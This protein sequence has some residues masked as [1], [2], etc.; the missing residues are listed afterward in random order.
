MGLKITISSVALVV[1]LLAPGA[2]AADLA[3]PGDAV[4]VV[5]GNKQWAEG[6][7]EDARKSFEQ[8]VAANPRSID[9]RMKLGGLLLSSRSYAAAI[10]TYQQTLSLDGDNAKAWIGLG[11]AYLHCGQKELSRGAF[12]AAVRADPGRK[13]QL[14]GLMEKPTE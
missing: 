8:A 14:A 10:Q 7:L 6:R 5:Q 11:M 4:L 2:R 3:N 1:A 13:T 12:E 9:A